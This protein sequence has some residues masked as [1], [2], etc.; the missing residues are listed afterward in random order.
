MGKS[1][2]IIFF[3]RDGVLTPSKE[4]SNV[5]HPTY[6]LGD[7]LNTKLK[8]SL[9]NLRE[10]YDTLSF[11][12]T[13]QP[14]VSRGKKNLNDLLL[15]NEAVVD[16]YGLTDSRMCIHDNKDNC[17]C[18][19]PLTGMILSLVNKYKF[20]IASEYIYVIG[21]RMSDV[22]LADNLGIKS[23]FVDYNY[24]ENI[25]YVRPE[26]TVHEPYEAIELINR[27]LSNEN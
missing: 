18:R 13:N 4:I 6:K 24:N 7:E 19:K 10:R 12:V 17:N 16:F 21:D 15:E 2:P 11:L 26:Y 20:D 22:R 3:D 25:N 9:D 5:P 14:D 1:K 8:I 27:I 23:I